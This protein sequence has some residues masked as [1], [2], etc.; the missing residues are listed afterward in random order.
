MDVR[1]PNGAVIR[2]VPEGTQKEVI[3]QKAISSGLATMEDFGQPVAPQQQAQISQELP[4]EVIAGVEERIPIP[5][6]ERRQRGQPQER[7]KREREQALELERIRQVNPYVAQQI[8]ETGGLDAFLVGAGKGLTNIARGVGLA[9]QE[10]DIEKLATEGLEA[11]SDAFTAGQITGET[12]P[13]LAVGGPLS[14]I[15]R[16][17]GARALAAAGTGGLE[18][19][20]ITKGRGGTTEQALKS[21][22][23]GSVLSGGG[24]LAPAIASRVGRREIVRNANRLLKQPSEREIRRNLQEAV[25]SADELKSASRDIYN[26]IKDMGITVNT[27]AFDSLTANAVKSA[28]DIGYKPTAANRN[29][30][31]QSSNVLDLFEDVRANPT[32]SDLEDIRRSAQN[33]ASV[34]SRA[35]NNQDAAISGAIVDEIDDFL[36]RIQTKDLSGQ[37]V[38]VGGDLA[39]AR[40]LWG[41]ARKQELLD[42]AYQIGEARAAGA[43][44]G[45]RNEFN[46]ILNNKKKA[47][48][49][50][51]KEKEAIRTVVK[52]APTANTFRRLGQMGFGRGQQT[53]VT[54]GLAGAGLGSFTLS[55]MFGPAGA[56]I[57][58]IIL[59]GIGTISKN[60]AERLT[61]NN[62]RLAGEI[63][64]AGPDSEKIIKAYL[65]STPKAQRSAEDLSNLLIRPD[66]KLIESFPDDIVQEA[67]T[68]ATQKRL[69]LAGATAGLAA[70]PTLAED[71]GG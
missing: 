58:A 7:A 12:A 44:R 4:P 54:S 27:E 51:E 65:K 34:A 40:G 33:A 18:S 32:V 36:S 8:E 42:E 31:P 64:R 41:R 52:G 55:S 56:A 60:L 61:R 11:Q 20:I 5:S 67:L 37:G 45:I 49:F 28:R 19:G 53:S 70:A 71:N 22:A 48:F 29:L 38:N 57:G 21:A 62:A 10:S 9:D 17:T 46:R 35:G 63:I 43:E 3:Q 39:L 14:G 15:A 23:I 13:F 50:N 16:T 25:P 24:A 26:N 30:N 59:P 68:T 47:R 69:Q 2:G 6:Y 66:V 1:L